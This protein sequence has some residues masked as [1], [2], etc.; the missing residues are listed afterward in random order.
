MAVDDQLPTCNGRLVLAQSQTANEFWTALLE[1]AYAKLKG[2]YEA[3]NYGQA[4]EALMD[5]SGGIGESLN[6]KACP[7][8]PDFVFHIL[9][10]AFL[11]GS[12]IC[13]YIDKEG[14][15]PDKL[16]CGLITK[17]CYALIDI[18]RL[19]MD[20]GQVHLIRL[21]NPWSND[22]EWNGPWSNESPE[23]LALSKKT[24]TKIALHSNKNGEFWI[25]W[26]DFKKYFSIFEFSHFN[27]KDSAY[28]WNCVVHTSRWQEGRNAGGCLNYKATFGK[29]PKYVLYLVDYDS[30]GNEKMCTAIISLI[31]KQFRLKLALHDEEQIKIGNP[32]TSIVHW[33]NQPSFIPCRFR[34]LLHGTS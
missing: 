7:Q 27:I 12:L 31:Q 6:F 19:K 24:R 9:Y 25:E 34:R 22:V 15:M 28:N 30:N 2:S 5:I 10:T 18:R 13:T 32:S 26:N 11:R 29:N 16:P 3:L 33:L 20:D 23:Y 21:K 1:K 14:E 4:T 8:T 17:H